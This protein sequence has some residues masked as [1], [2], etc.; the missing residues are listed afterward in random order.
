MTIPVLRKVVAK[1]YV[2]RLWNAADGG[3]KGNCSCPMC[4]NAMAIVQQLTPGEGGGAIEVDVC[5][6]CH[7]VWFDTHEFE[8]VLAGA[9]APVS[10][11]PEGGLSPKA[12]EMIAMARIESIRRKAEAE[13]ATSITPPVDDW[14]ALLAVFGFPVEENAPPIYRWPFVTWGVALL[15]TLATAWALW[16]GGPDVFKDFGLIPKE[17]FR[18]GGAHSGDEFLPARKPAASHRKRGVFADVR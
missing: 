1:D 8:P 4:N 7:A 3:A 16:L 13:D 6:P 11:I 17:A 18:D 5:R 15:M 14:Q 2:N 12:K 10:S 9:P